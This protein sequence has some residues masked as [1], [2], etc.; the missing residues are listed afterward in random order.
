MACW[1][2][3]SLAPSDQNTCLDHDKWMLMAKLFWKRTFKFDFT[4]LLLR[5]SGYEISI[6]KLLPLNQLFIFTEITFTLPKASGYLNWI[7]ELLLAFCLKEGRTFLL[8]QSCDLSLHQWFTKHSQIHFFRHN[9]CKALLSGILREYPGSKRL[10][11]CDYFH[12]PLF[13]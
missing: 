12:S 6:W 9:V 11:V 13:F 5:A 7:I 1:S 10:S 4:C 8:S 2:Q 3:G